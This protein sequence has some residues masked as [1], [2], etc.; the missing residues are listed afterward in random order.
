MP[1]HRLELNENGEIKIEQY[2]D[3]DTSSTGAGARR[4]LLR[5]R[6]IAKCWSRRSAAT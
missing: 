1:G 2:W 5:R 6:P 4:E 3:L